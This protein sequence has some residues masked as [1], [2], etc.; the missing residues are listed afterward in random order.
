MRD[1]LFEAIRELE[2]C[3]RTNGGPG[4]NRRD[5]SLAGTLDSVA[6]ALRKHISGLEAPDGLLH[7]VDTT[8]PAVARQVLE[9]CREHRDFIDEVRQLRRE[10]RMAPNERPSVAA[11][12]PRTAAPGPRGP[13]WGPRDVRS[14]VEE[15]A[16]ALNRHWEREADLIIEA[17]IHGIDRGYGSLLAAVSP[18]SHARNPRFAEE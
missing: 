13:D 12:R 6:R 7:L 2:E 8:A 18:H 1:Y 16:M 3:L 9:L 14:R 15:L 10:L 4:P 5:T 11:A 17:L